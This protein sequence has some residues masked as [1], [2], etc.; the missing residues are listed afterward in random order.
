MDIYLGN[1]SPEIT[2]QH[3]RVLFSQFGHVDGVTLIKDG[4]TG[5]PT[6]FGRVEMPETAEAKKAVASLEGKMLKGQEVRIGKRRPH[7]H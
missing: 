5:Q 1:L 6:G 7:T 4:Q 2:E 3:L